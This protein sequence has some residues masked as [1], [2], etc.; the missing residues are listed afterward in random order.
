[1]K[2]AKLA[3]DHPLALHIIIHIT[4]TM[5]NH[6]TGPGSVSEGEEAADTMTKGSMSDLLS[7]LA[8]MPS[9]LYMRI[10]RYHD[11]V[12]GNFKAHMLDLRVF[13]NCGLPPYPEHNLEVRPMKI[14]FV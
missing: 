1:M 3:G 13:K 14:T 9:H 11:S 7:H 2:Q 10:G 4:E 5:V 12:V 6:R 8:H